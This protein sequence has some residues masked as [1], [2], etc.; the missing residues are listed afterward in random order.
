MHVITEPYS[1]HLKL[2]FCALG[3]CLP[4]SVNRRRGKSSFDPLSNPT[5]LQNVSFIKVFDSKQTKQKREKEACYKGKNCIF[6]GFP[7]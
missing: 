1:K 7:P 3:K 5:C 4:I 2:S 6:S